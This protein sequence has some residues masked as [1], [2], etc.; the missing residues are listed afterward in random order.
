LRRVIPPAPLSHLTGFRLT[1]VASG[2]G[3]LTLPLS[4]WLQ[5]GDGTVDVDMLVELA[6]HT[7][8]VTTTQAGHEPVTSSLS[9]HHLR[10]CALKS[11]SL[12]ARG[13]V[14][15]AG[16]RNSPSPKSSSRT[17]WVAPWPTAEG[18]LSY[19]A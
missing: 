13:R 7:A 18:Q 8:I 6:L 19:T 15:N 16:I 17:L 4:P 3:S 14:L 12:I 11:E 2:A 9:V 5:L 1:D 10:P